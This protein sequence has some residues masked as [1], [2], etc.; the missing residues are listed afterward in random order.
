[1]SPEPISNLP[2]RHDFDFIFGRW[3]VAHR[4][5]KVRGAD[6]H[7]WDAFT[8]TATCEPRLD[9]LA[10]VEEMLCPARGWSGMALRT[11]DVE[12]REWSIYWVNSLTGRLQPPVRGR[13]DPDGGCV[14]EGPDTDGDRVIVARYIW[15]NITPDSARWSQA[16][17]YDEGASWETNW[18]MDFT[19]VL[20]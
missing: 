12:T 9:G 7:D 19:R 8:A 18:V 11:L 10:N 14:L 15:S 2:E 13:F 16:F 1:M 6:S 5:L 17:S 20:R 4:R 3:T